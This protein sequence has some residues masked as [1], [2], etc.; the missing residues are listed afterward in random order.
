M[1]GIETNLH[2]LQSCVE[3]CTRAAHTIQIAATAFE[4][5]VSQQN[6]Q[7]D[8]IAVLVARASEVQACARDQVG[9]LRELR[10]NLALLRAELTLSDTPQRRGSA[11][12][13][14]PG[15]RRQNGKEAGV[16][17]TLSHRVKKKGK[18]QS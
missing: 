13:Q 7:S 4:Q 17:R 8:F 10:Q 5:H 18:T 9:A 1:A 12:R 2:D 14:E 15:T 6:G 11:E 3:A 16:V